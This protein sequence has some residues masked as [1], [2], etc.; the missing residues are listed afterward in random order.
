MKFNAIP[1]LFILFF[2]PSL[3]AQM[4]GD[5]TV[6]NHISCDFATLTD[7]VNQLVTD[8]ISGPVRLL[9]ADTLFT[10]HFS[11]P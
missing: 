6:C 8:G 10:E 1:L 5:Y 9:L 7:A 4:S 2:S 3:N 11:I